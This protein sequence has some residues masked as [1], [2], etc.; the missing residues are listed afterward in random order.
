MDTIERLLQ[1]TPVR[2]IA[3]FR[4]AGVSR[5]RVLT[6]LHRG[7]V[8]RLRIGWYAR[9]GLPAPVREAIRVGGRLSCVS[10]LSAHGVDVPFDGRLHI[11]VPI[12]SAR[13]RD[14]AGRVR[15]LRGAVREQVVLHWDA[16]LRLAGAE[17]A[18]PLTVALDVATGCLDPERWLG[19]VEAAVHPER[20]LLRI[21]ELTALRSQL[22][23]HHARLLGLLRP[24]SDSPLETVFRLRM[25]HAGIP[26]LPQQP[27]PGGYRADF[28]LDD[29][30][31]IELDGRRYHGGASAFEHD[32]AR[33]AFLTALGYR[34]LRFSY[35]QVMDDWQGVL[36]V[37]R[38]L[39]RRLGHR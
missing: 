14:R 3:E 37:V 8:E 12:G 7:R 22:P 30:I 4:T 9:P 27:L 31:V 11:A 2:H 1:S 19:V 17:V 20:P 23:R 34:V 29:R 16:R 36:D 32:R 15:A 38:M 28:L 5:Q 35:R 26:V 33:D 18:E 6:A 10:A 13:L 24:G 21:E 39:R 25:M